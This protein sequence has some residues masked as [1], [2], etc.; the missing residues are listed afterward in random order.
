MKTFT[1]F[2]L[3]I[4]CTFITMTSLAQAQVSANFTGTPTSGCSPLIVT[5]SNLSTGATSYTWLFGNGNQ[6]T[7]NNPA[8]V[9]LNSGTYTVTLIACNGGVCDT[10]V[11]TNY[12]TV[13]ANPIAAFTCPDNAGCKSFTVNFQD[14]ST[15]GSAAITSWL[16][17]FG[18]GQLSMQQNPNH[19]YSNSGVYD[20]T[21]I[22]TD[23]N[24]CTGQISIPDYVTVVNQPTVNFT[25]SPLTSCF[26]PV[27]VTFNNNSSGVGTLTFV[28]D[29]GDGTTS[30]VVN[31]T[32]TYTSAGSFT[33]TL[34]CT[35]NYGCVKEKIKTNYINIINVISGFT[36]T[37]TSG[38]NSASVNFTNTTTP[39]PSSCTWNFGDGTTGTGINPTHTYGAS[40]TYSVTMTVTASGCT[41]V[42]IMPVTVVVNPLPVANFTAS[43]TS[44]CVVPMAVNFTN[45]STGATT[46][47]W[48]FGDGNVSTAT[49]PTHIYNSPGNYTVTLTAISAAGCSSTYTCTNCI[50]ITEP[51]ANFFADVTAGCI[52]LTVNFTDSSS[53]LWPI[54]SYYWDFGDGTTSNLANPTHTFT[55]D[56][57]YDVSLIIINSLG[58]TDTILM[59]DYIAAGDTPTVNF[60]ADPLQVCLHDEVYFYDSTDIGNIYNWSFG[61]GGTSNLQNPIYEYGDT[62][63]FTVSLTVINNGCMD[64][65]V[66]IN[67][68]TIFPPE[69]LF[70]ATFNCVDPYTVVFTDQSLAPDLWVWDF[71][72]GD[73]S[74]IQNPVHTY[75]TTGSYTVK[76][77]V[78]DTVGNCFDDHNLNITI[79][80]PVADFT[81]DKTFGCNPLTVIFN[82][83]ISVD[84][85]TYAWDFGDGSS[86]NAA[87]PSHTYTATGIYD[88]SLIITDVHG[89]SDTATQLQLITV[90]GATANF[91]ATPLTGCTPL[92]VNFTDFSSSY[93]GNITAWVWTFGDGN[94]S[95][96]QNPSN[97][98]LTPGYY[99][100]TL[101]VTDDNG[102]TDVITM[103]NYI[104]PTF[105]TADF[106][107]TTTQGCVGANLTFSSTSSGQGLTYVWDF[108]DGS[109]AT[110][111][112]ATHQYA[113]EGQYTVTLTATDVNGC[114]DSEIKIDYIS[115]QDPIAA[116]GADTT[117]ANCPPL[118]VVFSNQTSG[119]IVS[120]TWDFGDGQGSN[121]TNPSHVY[122]Q[123]GNYTVTLIVTNNL[124]CKDTLVMPNLINVQ[125]PNGTFTFTP[126][127]GC[128]DLSVAFSSA[129]NNTVNWLWDFGDGNVT[130]GSNNVNHTYTNTGTF[131]PVLIL[132]DP[133]GCVFSIPSPAPII[134]GDVT[135]NFTANITA[136]CGSGT[137]NF[138][139][140]STSY[141]NTGVTYL[142]NFGDGTSS[143]A[144]NPTHAYTSSG[145]FTVTLTVT[146]SLG[147][148]DVLSMPNYI[149]VEPAPIANFSASPMVGCVPLTVNFTDLSTASSPI[150]SWSWTFTGGGTSNLQNPSYTWVTSGNKTALLTITT[151]TGCTDSYSLIIDVNGLPNANAG[152]DKS[153]CI[154]S[155]TVLAG[156]SCSGC[157]YLWSPAT[158]LN[159]PTIPQ[160]TSSVTTTTTYTLT[161][162]AGNGCTNSDVMVLTVN[163]LPVITITP[164]TAICSGQSVNLSATGGV[165]YSW[166]PS[167]GLSCANCA[168]PV[169][170]PTITTTYTVTVQSVFGCTNTASVTITVNP[171]PTGVTT[172]NSS[173]CNGQS[174]T[175]NATG[176]GTYSWAPST[177][178]S[179]VNC[180][181]PVASPT[182]TTTYTCVTTSTAGCVRTNSVTITVN[183]LPVLVVTPASVLCSGASI[184]LSASGAA[185][186]SWSPSTGLSCWNCANPVATPTVDITY[187]VT[188]TS[189][190]G[191]Q[192]TASV[193]IDVL[194]NTASF[195]P[196]ATVLCLPGTV[197]F[198]NTSSADDGIVGYLWNF[199]DG[200]TSSLLSPVNIYLTSGTFTVSL[201]IT[202]LNGCV[203]S[204]TQNITI[205]ALPVANAGADITICLGS[206]TILNGSGG[207]TY[208]WSPA[209]GLNNPNIA[210]PIATPTVTT[211]Y[212]LSVTNAAGC[213]ATDV[214]TITTEQLTVDLNT[215]PSTCTSTSGS[216]TAV[217]N[218]SGTAPYSYAWSDGTTTSNQNYNGLP[219]GYIA[220]TVTDAIGCTA[221]DSDWIGLVGNN[222]D[223]TFSYSGNYCLDGN[224]I[225]FNSNSNGGGVNHIWDF[226]DSSLNSSLQDPS[227]SYAS[228]D[229]YSVIHIV[230]K[231]IYCFDTTI[232][233]VIIY[234]SPIISG[235][236]NDISCFGAND[237]GIDIT[238]SSGSI[239]FA[240]MW[241]DA[242]LTEDRTNLIP[243]NYTVT[244]TDIMGCQDSNSFLIT[245]PSALILIESHNDVLCYGGNNASIDITVTGGTIPYSFI[246]ND[247]ILT[248]DRSALIAGSYS[249]TVTDNNSCS[250]S[251]TINIIEPASIVLN[252]IHSDV[253]CNAGSDAAI[254][255]TVSGGVLPYSYL[256]SNGDSNED[257]VNIVVGIYSVTVTD[258][259]G[260][261]STISIN[262][263]EPTLLAVTETH[264]DVS[265]F[266]LADGSIDITVTGGVLPYAFLWNDGDL[267]EDRSAIIAGNYSVIITDANGCTTNIAIT[268]TEPATLA[269][270]ETHADVL[271]FGGN[272]ANIDI[273][274]TGGTLPYAYLWNDGDLNEDRTALVAGNYS[275]IITDAN[276]CTTN[277]AVSIIEPTL[278]VLSET[279]VDVLCFGGNNGSID[280]TVLG[281]VLPY[282]YLWNDGDTNEDR[283]SLFA[284]IYTIDVTDANACVTSLT[285]NIVEPTAIA[286][287]ETHINV[288][289]NGFNN[290]SIDISISGGVAPYS[291]LW[292]NTS[293][294]EDLNS[295]I[296]GSYTLTVTD[297]NACTSTI[298][299]SV[300]E[301]GILTATETHADVYCFGGSDASIDITMSGG[302]APYSYLWNDGTLTEDRSALSIGTYSVIVTDAN[303]CTTTISINIVEPMLLIL[304]E[305]HVD[306]FCFTG[307]NGS[308][309]LTINGGVAPYTYLWNDGDL[310]ED[311]SLLIAGI[312]DVTVTDANGCIANLSATIVEPADLIIAGSHTDVSC[313]AGND[314]TISITI[315]GSVAPYTYI[316]NDGDTNED[317]TNLTAATYD[318]TVT[319]FNACI[320]T[321]S[322]IVA[323]PTLLSLS[324]THVDVLCFGGN[325]AS[326][327]LTVIGGTTPYNFAWSNSGVTE[328]LSNITAGIYS[329]TVT[330]ANSCLAILSDTIFEPTA[331]AISETHIDVTCAGGNDASIDI[332]LTGGVA[333]YTYLWN[334]LITTE[335]RDTLI[336]GTYTVVATDSNGCQITQII[337]V[338]E[339]H[340]LPTVTVTPDQAICFGQSLQLNATGG[341]NYSWSPITGLDDPNISNPIATPVIT[342]TY[343][344]LVT[345][346]FTCQN[347]GTV[348]VTVNPIPTGITTNDTT[349]CEGN[350]V[351]IIA[352]G[353][354]TY[355]W[356]PSTGLSCTTCADPIAS[357]TTTTIYHV[358]VTNQFSCA[359]TDTFVLT[360]EPLPNI[361]ASPDQ[362][363]CF[364]ETVQLASTGG[365]LYT[366]T[367]VTGLSCT[368]CPD[369]FATP[370]STTVYN[371][372]VFSAFGCSD[373][374][375]ITITV[376][377]LPVITASNDITLCS[378]EGMTISASGG[379]NYT[380]TPNIGLSNEFVANP[381][382][383]PTITTTYIVTGDNQFGC[384]DTDTMTVNVIDKVDAIAYS[385]TSLCLGGSAQLNAEVISA[386]DFGVAYLWLPFQTLNDASIPNPIAT[387]TQTTVYQSIVFSGACAPDTNYVTVTINQPPVVDAGA[388][389]AITEG[390]E[391]Q[392]FAISNN[393][394]VS[395]FWDPAF[396][397][398]CDDCFNPSFTPTETAYYT[399]YVTDQNGCVGVDS[400]LV[401]IIGYCTNDIIYVPNTFTP[402]NDG[403][404]DILYVRGNGFEIT[405][406]NIYDRWGQLMW[407]SADKEIG[408]DG[409]YN[410]LK[411]SSGVFVY[412]LEAIC[413]NNIELKKSGNVTV[414]R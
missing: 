133:Q 82:S 374:E 30:S 385:D 270:S 166:S 242:G 103:P 115:I 306:V 49:N 308:I 45:S 267:N 121:L 225:D 401:D 380:W 23:A 66:M 19:T 162:T 7:Q 118:I 228:A 326:I 261:L 406:F 17:D 329:V 357:P 330:D 125:G 139:S 299:I 164:N 21:L 268:I 413:S 214:V 72:D 163:P 295:I 384:T 53:S 379:V 41:E 344:V 271:C 12:I 65:L 364:G 377:P 382:A 24:G 217:T 343:N 351:Q 204:T 246:W 155:S 311:R 245:E 301:P 150:V 145:S 154:G 92:T 88:V 216:A 69:A 363:I 146:N 192:S 315:S 266:G 300:T 378:G 342:T 368:A 27:N 100:V 254:D 264:V 91:S 253:S 9:Y 349:I 319:D 80:D 40:G 63:V 190:F 241:S 226:G 282:A 381:F 116:F 120:Q 60:G 143:N 389:L 111:A 286:I 6:S 159:F 52:D 348:T 173:I 78:E 392:L 289:C 15:P 391:V 269:V 42:V 202:T 177:G 361:V 398:S 227:H 223:A 233:T 153:H 328:D 231:G 224:Y 148:T 75:L 175:L 279:H 176:G 117:S 197:S 302:T 14:I 95:I 290:G 50:Q 332:T 360:I 178:L 235:N 76:L 321:Y 44:T 366:W 77:Y 35:N 410:G 32:H 105:P 36:Y 327:D 356:T 55:Q 152:S 393:S 274:V 383:T 294:T 124:G 183:P 93:L 291:Y 108:G 20:V 47:N 28:W 179:C 234:P 396:S 367:P 347:T 1:F 56:T 172:A 70:D 409:I 167:T 399:V 157:T 310:N 130:S 340:P 67:L 405:L 341:I 86:S 112:S 244:V 362:A 170:T 345:D 128:I 106:T 407:S 132:T 297:A 46:Y 203:N 222:T 104:N 134:A 285:I 303:S 331:L 102:C 318:V 288:T 189:A 169:A 230:I 18:D 250:T 182:V 73:S 211:T 373:N 218:N 213:Q 272:N 369:P 123:P 160:P 281:G 137:V 174:I 277:I 181:S 394:N 292:S 287:T 199:G 375:D 90:Y 388:D 33:V 309:D 240:Y 284:G 265:C 275:V 8:A 210:N 161:V 62:G 358:V 370:T 298:T 187:T 322:V 51:I 185:T 312:Y 26:F 195:I 387:P 323:E 129:T 325:N 239:P 400:V 151:S 376:N 54:T 11:K 324:S 198:N 316:W 273:T 196:S 237:G 220:V 141:P 314:G 359:I 336:A 307:N 158:G 193:V 206:S 94:Q 71:G 395:Y 39:A 390:T 61:D 188:G 144:Q 402:N 43:P 97:N 283:S 194:N 184:N 2:K 85:S 31:P 122:T 186:Y 365:V 180:S 205:N 127:Q 59:T 140:T 165:I 126:N 232:A 168:N 249:V 397:L 256:W 135:A 386:S 251:I 353:G 209:T 113:I 412:Y 352:T 34:T 68:I 207:V 350:S 305:T 313:F 411:V 37:Q 333:P 89:C 337:N 201:T 58:C 131:N 4:V 243:G 260:C 257:L 338:I 48:D 149:T 317:R 5:F 212:T 156:V 96:L 200:N 109:T 262:I 293:I 101:A 404:N 339:M 238:T 16:W 29:F 64:S 263:T 138:T 191:C 355:N 74:F 13:F 110:G 334:D 252:E 276:G 215:A 99:S 98:Y 57:V 408:W 208:L 25:A 371:V 296:A 346:V 248:E 247:G 219:P 114:V 22:V 136:I 84:A 38:C 320:E 304:S 255:L 278:V 221:T 354:V 259:N 107:V 79:T 403:K 335:D 3:G 142:W 414:V 87:N 280:L 119:N 147:C 10:M 229:T 236:T 171:I 258:A 83:A 81:V 372:Q